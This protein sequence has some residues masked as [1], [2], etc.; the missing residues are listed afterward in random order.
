[1]EYE[2]SNE[3][4]MEIKPM[5]ELRK[6]DLGIESVQFS[7]NNNIEMMTASHDYSICFWDLNKLAVSRRV[8][9]GG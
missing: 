4:N 5:H 7:P 8:N 2:F 1:M 6:H 9:L 3:V